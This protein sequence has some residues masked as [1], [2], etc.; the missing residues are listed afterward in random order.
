MRRFLSYLD[1][2]D[3][4]STKRVSRRSAIG[5]A[6][7]L[8]WSTTPLMGQE[9]KVEE[10]SAPEVGDALDQA[11]ATTPT[12]EA[13]ES[14]PQPKL[15]PYPPAPEGAQRLSKK[16]RA[17]MDREKKQVI[18]DARVSLRRGLLE[19]FACPPNTKE[20]ESIVAVD[21]EAFVLHAGLLAVGAEPGTPVEFAPKY[22]PPT[23]TQI[24]I[25][26]LW[27]DEQGKQQKAKAQDWIRDARTGKPMDLP[28]VFA[29]SGFWRDEETGRSGYHADMGDLVCLANFSTAMLDVPAE[30][31]SDNAGL[32]Y[33]AYTERVPPLGWPVRLVL[34]PVLDQEDSDSTADAGAES[35][36][37]P[38][39]Q[40][41]VGKP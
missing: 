28:W 8:L 6:V 2:C 13:P 9:A 26:V 37:S 36:K 19:M 41:A 38:P 39:A 11:L 15:Q 40:E 14:Q 32:L 7:V 33:E 21:S 17:W 12:D 27:V 25:D 16:G 23:G 4:T 31:T 34:K 10:S 35:P 1:C 30:L 3:C 22:K 18:V 24:D 20:H 29:G 5:V